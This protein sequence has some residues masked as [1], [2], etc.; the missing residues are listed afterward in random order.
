VQI[1]PKGRFTTQNHEHKSTLAPIAIFF[2]AHLGLR[3]RFCYCGISLE[4]V[5]DNLGQQIGK[6]EYYYFQNLK[7]I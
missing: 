1:Y 2:P 4:H 5:N 6:T 3:I 7:K